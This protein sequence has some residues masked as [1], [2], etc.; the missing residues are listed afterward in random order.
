LPPRKNPIS[1]AGSSKDYLISGYLGGEPGFNL[2]GILKEGC[3]NE[4][5]RYYF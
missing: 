3:S 4:S 1:S 5:S 2:E